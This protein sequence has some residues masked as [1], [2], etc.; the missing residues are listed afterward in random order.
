MKNL[1]TKKIAKMAKNEGLTITI[2]HPSEWGIPCSPKRAYSYSVLDNN[3]FW[4]QPE[5]VDAW[6]LQE[7]YYNVLQQIEYNNGE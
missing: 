2:G 5:S 6:T 1:T 7:L 4:N 3:G